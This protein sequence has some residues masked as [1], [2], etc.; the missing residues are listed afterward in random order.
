[1]ADLLDKLEAA[2]AE[3]AR[4]E[5]EIAG[6]PCADV[7]HRWKFFGGRHCGCEPGSCSVPVHKCSVCGDYDYGEN[8]ESEDIRRRCREDRSDADD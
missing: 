1:M 8:D 6:A 5:R 2:R 4:L 3:V 7:G